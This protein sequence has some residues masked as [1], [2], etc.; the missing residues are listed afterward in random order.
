MINKLLTIL[1]LLMAVTVMGQRRPLAGVVMS[2][3]N[4]VPQVYVINKAT[5]NEVQ[6]NSQGQFSIMAQP[7]DYLAVHSKDIEARDFLISE[8]SFKDMPYRLSVA[9]KPYELDEVTINK[10]NAITAEGMGIVPKGQKKYT[11]QG[12]KL[13]TASSNKPVYMLPLDL[14]TGSMQLDPVINAI[15]GKT[16]ML[17]HTVAAEKNIM[18]VEKLNGIYTDQEIE[19]ELKVPEGYA[20][21]FLYYAVTDK[22]LAGMLA[23]GNDNAVKFLLTRLADE[24]RQLITNE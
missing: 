14:L 19:T 16:R 8:N 20:K 2:G 22:E 3:E 4:A 23:S 12:R 21:G 10:D 1:L 13:Y 7:G 15:N 24:Y 17:K 11:P 5:G 9:Y 18:L 6:T